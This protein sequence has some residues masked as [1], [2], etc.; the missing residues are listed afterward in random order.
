MRGR[1]G[2]VSIADMTH[3]LD[4]RRIL[5]IAFRDDTVHGSLED[6]RGGVRTFAGWLELLAAIEELRAQPRE[7]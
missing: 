7:E 1:R 3:V 2:G 4:V 5:R 6:E